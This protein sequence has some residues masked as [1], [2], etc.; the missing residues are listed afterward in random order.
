M[1]ITLAFW[2]GG[3][4]LDPEET[5]EQLHAG[6]RVEGVTPA[7]AA[8]VVAAFAQAQP[9]WQWDGQLFTLP[10]RGGGEGGA[11]DVALG[12][13]LVELV[14]YGVAGNDLNAVIDVMRPLG[15]R[16]YDPQIAERFA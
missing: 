1:S 4:D 7:D 6:E 16:L 15:Y 10:A 13:Q 9:T 8:Q 12:E 3:D 14:G 5:Y 11:F 2:A